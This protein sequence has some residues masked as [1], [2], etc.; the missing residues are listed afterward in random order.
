[1]TVHAP[2][3]LRDF[4]EVVG[5]LDHIVP[6]GGSLLTKIGPCVVVLPEDLYEELLPL[7]GQCVGVLRVDTGKPYRVRVVKR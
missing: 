1:M 4:E 2:I 3:I 5:T 6:D 7:V